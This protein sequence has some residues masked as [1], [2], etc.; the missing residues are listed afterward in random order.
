MIDIVKV[1]NQ[2]TIVDRPLFHQSTIVDTF[3]SFVL[4]FPSHLR[5]EFFQGQLKFIAHSPEF[6]RDRHQ[7]NHLTPSFVL[8]KIGL[9][10][11]ASLLVEPEYEAGNPYPK[12]FCLF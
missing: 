6:I 8:K 10:P 1:A 9:A 3:L 5:L 2:S 11:K 12:P 7:I 4:F